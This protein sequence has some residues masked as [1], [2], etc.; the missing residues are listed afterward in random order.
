MARIGI[1]TW[2][3]DG[4][5]RP[6]L[7][8]AAG[9]KQ[10]GHAV[11]VI[12]TSVD[13]KDYNPIARS[14]G[15][16]LTQ[17]GQEQL[18]ADPELMAQGY[19]RLL[20][21]RDPIRQVRLIWEGLY[22]PAAE[23]IIAAARELAQR[24]DLVVGHFMLHPV[25]AACEAAGTPHVSVTMCHAVVPSPWVPVGVLPDLGPTLNGLLWKLAE[26][27]FRWLFGKEVQ[28]VR[29]RLGL[30]PA[31]HLLKE[32]FCSRTLDLVPV[33]PIFWAPRPDMPAPHRIAGFWDMPDQ[34]ERRVL[35]LALEKFLQ[36]GTPPLFL[37]FGSLNTVEMGEPALRESLEL[38]TETA[39]LT[40]ER[41]IVQGPWSRLGVVP[42]RQGQ[43]LYRLER[44]PHEALLPRC[45]AAVHHGGAGTTHSATRA[46]LP[47]VVAAH[48][49]DQLFWGRELKRLGFGA[50]MH[51]RSATPA[52]LASE[53]RALLESSGARARAAD[54][55]RELT[56]QDGVAMACSAIQAFFSPPE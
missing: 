1:Q 18:R 43:E 36:E 39:R 12:C 42:G 15:V 30:P 27:T 52:H 22:L 17:V 25:A 50:V 24:S 32:A 34:G 45:L 28:A 23:P 10:R 40:G 6:F 56:E 7:A 46:G 33:S 13:Q 26:P 44:A 2:G 20:S 48:V 29:G 19:A 4:D 8:L 35:D 21:S 16:P 53:L 49:A 3:S 37:G 47:Q 31:R 11:E 41:A 5:I 9:L 14:I 54:A 38:L 55:G 51:R